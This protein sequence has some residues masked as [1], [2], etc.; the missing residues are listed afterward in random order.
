MASYVCQTQ[1]T[2]PA[3]GGACVL[4]DL[5][6]PATIVCKEGYGKIKGQGICI[7]GV[8]PQGKPKGSF[9]GAFFHFV[10]VIT[11]IGALAF[12]CVVLYKKFEDKMPFSSRRSQNYS[13]PG[14]EDLAT[15]DF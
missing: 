12:G 2:C 5:C 6:D 10:F 15:G 11:L 1:C 7:R 4:G 9:I 8:T 3:D 14:Y 13:G